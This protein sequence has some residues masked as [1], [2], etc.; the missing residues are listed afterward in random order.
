VR[1]TRSRDTLRSLLSPSQPSS[2][3]A[4]GAASLTSGACP[5][6]VTFAALGRQMA[7]LSTAASAG[8][9]E[10][11]GG[12]GEF[13]LRVGGPRDLSIF[14]LDAESSGHLCL[15][16]VNGGIKFWPPQ[17]S[18]SL[19]LMPRRSMFI[20]HMFTSLRVVMPPSRILMLQL[21]HSVLP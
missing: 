17:I 19:G 15:G 13:S 9:G 8:S 6:G 14:V 18:V 2:S 7:G 21:A 1:A 16:A 12:Y 5:P 10:G 4:S 11:E 3:S 20:R